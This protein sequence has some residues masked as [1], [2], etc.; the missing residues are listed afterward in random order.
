[1]KASDRQLSFFDFTFDN[2]EIPDL[3]EFDFSEKEAA[4]K[5][6]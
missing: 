2:K 1:M 3:F 4:K 5:R 6:L